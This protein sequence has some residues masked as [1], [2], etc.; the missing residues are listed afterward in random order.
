MNI[1]TRT[2]TQ[3]LEM[4]NEWCKYVDL[5][6]SMHIDHMLGKGPTKAAFVSNLRIIAD[7]MEKLL[8]EKEKGES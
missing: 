7:Q 2:A 1:D 3:V 6:A 4:H 5:I 8:T